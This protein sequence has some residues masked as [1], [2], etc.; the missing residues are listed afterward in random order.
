MLIHYLQ[1]GRNHLGGNVKALGHLKI[2]KRILVSVLLVVGANC[3]EGP[4][5]L[6]KA[7][8]MAQLEKSYPCVR[9]PFPIDLLGRIDFRDEA[10]SLV[11]LAIQRM[12]AGD[13]QAFVVSPADTSRIER[14]S[15]LDNRDGTARDDGQWLVAIHVRGRGSSFGLSVDQQTGRIT[16]KEDH[17]LQPTPRRP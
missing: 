16:V 14:A 8:R 11:S 15:A 4:K 12:A 2:Q 9:R 10:C 17:Y 1:G 6:T 13:G 7:D 3:A 5:L